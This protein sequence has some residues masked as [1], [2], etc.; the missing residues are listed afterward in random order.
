MV[1]LFALFAL[2]ASGLAMAV[3]TTCLEHCD[4]DGPD[5]TCPPTCQDCA[6]CA[7]PRAIQTM[8]AGAAP[9]QALTSTGDW[10]AA[11][12]PASPDPGE[13]LRVPKL[14]GA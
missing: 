14:L 2:E 7:Q 11:G 9:S 1:V 8:S 6:C 12:P 4:D 5:G 13:I 10:P 3:E